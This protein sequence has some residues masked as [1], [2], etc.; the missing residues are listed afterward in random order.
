LLHTNDLCQESVECRGLLA[1]YSLLSIELKHVNRQIQQHSEALKSQTGLHRDRLDGL[2]LLLQS[3]NYERCV[4]ARE[5][6]E[7]KQVV[8]IPPEIDLISEEE[9]SIKVGA[10]E[11]GSVEGHDLV[12]ARLNDELL[13]R[14]A[15]CQ[16]LSSLRARKKA[17]MEANAVSLKHLDD[18]QAALS[19]VIKGHFTVSKYTHSLSVG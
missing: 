8:G 12:L 15:L 11:R 1:Q 3:L 4:I 19:T 16:Q 10:A 17:V 18:L 7:C 6:Q 5:I 13:E 2:N 9:Y 14:K